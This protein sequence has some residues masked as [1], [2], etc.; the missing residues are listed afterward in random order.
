M[1]IYIFHAFAV[2]PGFPRFSSILLP[3]LFLLS[4]ALLLRLLVLPVLRMILSE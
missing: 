4:D 1:V 2:K 3:F